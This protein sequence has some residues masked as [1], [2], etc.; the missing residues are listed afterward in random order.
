MNYKWNYAKK[1]MNWKY[2]DDVCKHPRRN[3][4]MNTGQILFENLL[5]GNLCLIPCSMNW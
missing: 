1:L 5:M 3:K 2:K 4:N